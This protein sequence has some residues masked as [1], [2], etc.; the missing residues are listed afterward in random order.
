MP[1]ITRES[2]DCLVLSVGP[3][4]IKE[5]RKAI[6]WLLVGALTIS[7]GLLLILWVEG[8]VSFRFPLLLGCVFL[9]LGVLSGIHPFVKQYR[10]NRKDGQLA[11]MSGRPFRPAPTYGYCPLSQFLGSAVVR[12]D[13]DYK[14]AYSS[15]RRNWLGSNAL[16][17]MPEKLEHATWYD[18]V[19]HTSAGA[20]WTLVTG[21]S[22]QEAGFIAE[23][24]S[25]FLGLSVIKDEAD[26]HYVRGNALYDQGDCERAISEYNAAI[27]RRNDHAAAYFNRGLAYADCGLYAKA[28]FDFD[29]AIALLPK[30]AEAY[31]NRGL[32]Y[33]HQDLVDKAAADFNQ[34][35]T[36]SQ[37][38]AL[39]QQA[40][41]QL[42]NL[43]VTPTAG[44]PDKGNH[45]PAHRHTTR[46]H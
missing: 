14:P 15:E 40:E 41:E 16:I 23:Q 21:L 4:L 1:K 25:E 5:R 43:G 8:S 45:R 2:A 32:A 7:V 37:D 20:K 19:L 31:L 18:V 39:R 46:S 12:R 17:R 44:M 6:A 28:T 11:V 22:A 29:R 13:L 9:L 30:D 3:D 26:E 38:Q 42:H 10:F 27:E 35:L 33:S 24:I 34:V 36:L